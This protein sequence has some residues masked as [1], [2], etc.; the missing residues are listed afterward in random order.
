MRRF[1]LSIGAVIVTLFVISCT[2]NKGDFTLVNRADEPI[3]R[4]S[5]TICGQKIELV[6]IQPG[7]SASGSYDVKSDSH[8]TI[9]LEFQSGKIMREEVGYVTNGMD[10]QHEITVTSSTIEITDSNVN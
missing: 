9:T 2:T 1:A 6:N 3:A 10:F 7:E 8:Y 4:A 5:V